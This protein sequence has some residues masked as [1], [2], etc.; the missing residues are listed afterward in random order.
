M[1]KRRT[2]EALTAISERIAVVTAENGVNLRKGPGPIFESI[3]SADW[4]QRVAILPLPYDTEV[5][6]YV[7]A[8][9]GETVGWI[10]SLFLREVE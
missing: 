6:G 10:N 4:K 9:T 7:L 5:P 8:H 2:D 3:G 1:A